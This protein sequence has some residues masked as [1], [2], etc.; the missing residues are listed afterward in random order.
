[1]ARTASHVAST[2]EDVEEIY[3]HARSHAPSSLDTANIEEEEDNPPEPSERHLHKLSGFDYLESFNELRIWSKSDVDPLARSNTPMLDR[4]SLHDTSPEKSSKVMLIHDYQGGYN[5]YEAC[6]GASTDTDM[7][8]CE[9]L[10]HVETFV[11]FSH[12]LVTIPPPTWINTCHRNGVYCLG[13]FIVEPGTKE[14][15]AILEA[16][17]LGGYWVASQLAAIAKQYGFDG[18]LVNIEQSFPLLSWSVSG[19]EGFLRQ[20]RRELGPKRR[21]VW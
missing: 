10:Q 21:V 5:D 13:T 7:Y 9:Y 8:S 12:K 17:D 2:R 20:L 6:Q 19:M 14:A 1:M 18:W 11:Y 15:K 4:H 3:Q 16:G